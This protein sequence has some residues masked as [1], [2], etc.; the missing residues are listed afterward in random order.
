MSSVTFV[1][2]S[3][4][5]TTISCSGGFFA[6]P[7]AINTH[8]ITKRETIEEYEKTF[9]FIKVS[10]WGILFYKYL[11]SDNKVCTRV[12]RSTGAVE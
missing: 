4:G 8:E 1:F 3:S 2:N 6:S 5:E 9:L 12:A 7:Q 11:S 10:M